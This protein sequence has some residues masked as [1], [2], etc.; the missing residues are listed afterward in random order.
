[1][2]TPDIHARD[3]PSETAAVRTVTVVKHPPTVVPD[4]TL[5]SALAVSSHR[6]QS[7]AAALRPSLLRLVRL[8]LHLTLLPRSL[9]MHAAGL[10][11]AR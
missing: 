7:L 8:P 6:P 11:T 1:M 3:R 5:N 9:K 10:A 2:D 4:V